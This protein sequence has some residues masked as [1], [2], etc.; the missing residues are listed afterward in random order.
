M[1][2]VDRIKEKCKEKKT[3]MGGLEKELGLGNGTIRLW[4]VKTPGSDKV[5]LVAEKLGVSLDW[6]LLG[7]EAAELTPNEQEL[8]ELYRNTNDIGQPLITNHAK[9]IQ[10]A[11]PRQQEIKPEIISS[12]S[13][14]G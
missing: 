5:I 13:K 3:S 9:D 2:I 7:K 10:K 14:I 6:I 8:I 1:P 4:D 12:D 11:L